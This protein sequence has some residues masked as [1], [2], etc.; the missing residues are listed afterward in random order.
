M[1]ITVIDQNLSRLPGAERSSSRAAPQRAE[2]SDD[3]E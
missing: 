1:H 3:A 2:R